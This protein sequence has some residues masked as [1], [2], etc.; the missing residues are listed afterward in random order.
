MIVEIP[1]KRRG[2]RIYIREDISGQ[3]FGRLT[4][5]CY[6]HDDPKQDCVSIWKCKCDC[7]GESFVRMAALKCGRISSCGCVFFE[8]D[9][10]VKHPLHTIWTGIKQRCNNPNSANYKNYGG[11]GIRFYERWSDSYISFYEDVLPI[12]KKGLQIDRIDNNGHYEPGNIRWVDSKTNMRNRRATILDVEK[13]K[14]IRQSTLT[15]K[16]LSN[17]YGVSKQT[18]SEIRKKNSPVWKDAI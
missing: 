13:V 16:Q 17:I 7:G 12:Y 18:I 1:V 9:S 6:S 4:V 15:H 14:E 10:R 11:R 3:K 2:N 8:K 5:V